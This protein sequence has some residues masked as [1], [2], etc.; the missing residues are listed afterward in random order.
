M[1]NC[2]QAAP[3]IEKPRTAIRSSSIR[4]CRLTASIASRTSTSP[5]NL[6]ALQYRPYGCRT[7]VSA[8]ENSPGC[9]APLVEEIDLAQRLAAAVEP[10]VEPVLGPALGRVGSGITRP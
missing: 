2:Q 6:S 9:C 5:A 7:I 1:A 3:P 4:Y 8:G 10:D